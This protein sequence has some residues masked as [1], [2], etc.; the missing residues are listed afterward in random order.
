MSS[1]EA[2]DAID[3]LVDAIELY[4]EDQDEYAEELL[5]EMARYVMDDV[6]IDHLVEA[7]DERESRPVTPDVDDR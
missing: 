1:I 7:L 4:V 6:P 3:E 5:L 2:K